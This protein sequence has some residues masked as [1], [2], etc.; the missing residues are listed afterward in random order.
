MSSALATD[1]LGPRAR[2]R[3][4]ILTG[5]S[6]LVL[7]A[8][9]VA[10]LR[11]FGASG[12]L[13]AEL[14]TD[15]FQPAAVE[16]F[17]RAVWVNLRLAGVAMVL[18][19]GIGLLL[20]L[21]RLSRALPVR[22]LAGGYVEFFRAMPVLLLILFSRFG[23]PNLGISFSDFTYVVLALTAYNSATLGEIFRAGILSLARGQSEA[24]YAV[25]LTYRQTMASVVLPQA[26]RRM[27]PAIVSQLVTLLK[28]TSLAYIIGTLP[29]LLRRAQQIGERLNN[30]L[31]ALLFAALVFIIINYL[32]SRLA[33]WLEQRQ[34]RTLGVG[35]VAL[36][37]DE[38]V[39]LTEE[40]R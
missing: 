19:L 17:A 38:D 8:L 12:Q 29:D 37:A 28:D 34:R 7:L 11:Q 21:G 25:G 39:T 1:A 13:E 40:G 4:R 32:L 15:L 35:A 36:A 9:V 2:S 22:L 5:I 6:L 16:L 31:Q 24:S 3:V 20:A 26:L 18:S 23:L 10:A 27:T 30:Q 33:G 14:Y